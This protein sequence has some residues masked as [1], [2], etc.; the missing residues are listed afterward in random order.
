MQPQRPHVILVT[1]T[2]LLCY[3][4]YFGNLAWVEDTIEP[5]SISLVV[6]LVPV[7]IA[8]RHHATGR[9]HLGGTYLY[10]I[11]LY[12]V[13][14]SNARISFLRGPLKGERAGREGIWT[15]KRKR[16]SVGRVESK[17]EERIYTHS[18]WAL[19]FGCARFFEVRCNKITSL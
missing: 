18:P 2:Y 11:P 19:I 12:V 15:V 6:R 5:V 16:N 3:A 1:W 9:W 10:D 17:S 4:F 13:P 14:T 7:S 8:S